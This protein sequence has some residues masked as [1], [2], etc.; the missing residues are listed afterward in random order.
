MT[1]TI[2]YVDVATARSA[3]GV[4]I[5]VSGLV[6]SP[7]S[8]AAKGLFQVAKVPFV[9]VRRMRDAQDITAWTGIDNVPVVLH[10]AEPA[11][12]NWSAIT[13]LA[14]RLAGPDVLIPEDPAAR[15]ETMGVLHEIA[16]EDGIGWNARLAMID[17]TIKSEGKR[18]FPLPIGQYLAARYG[19]AADTAERIRP[20]AERQ[21]RMLRDRLAAQQAR[22][23]AYLGGAHVSALDVYLATFLTPLTA[24]S[25]AD[26][27][28]LVPA[29]RA[30]F[31]CAHEEL[32]ALVPAELLAHRTMVF[33]RHLTWPI[34]L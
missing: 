31:G 29:L 13:A 32:G 34:A 3:P 19:Y 28:T 14:S 20:R 1:A 21:L 27:P 7:W 23:H 33:E 9:A 16:G 30:A 18:G 22:G 25:E 4:R 6:P 26:C 2:D 8:E 24:I 15:A 12:T 5:V 10:N 17:A 11:R